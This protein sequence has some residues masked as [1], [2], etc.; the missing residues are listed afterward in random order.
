MEKLIALCKEKYDPS[1]WHEKSREAFEE[2]F[3][4]RYPVKA[5]TGLQFRTPKMGEDNVAFS[6]I[7]HSSNPSS[8]AYSG[9]S[10]VLFPISDGP[11]LIALGIGTQGLYPDDG[12]LGKPGH[13]RKTNAITKWLNSEFSKDASISWSK[14]DPTRKDLNIPLSVVNSFPNYSSIFERYGPEIYSFVVGSES[15]L[16]VALKAFIDLFLEE[17]GVVVRSK[18]EGDANRIKEKYFRYIFPITTIEN[19]AELLKKRKYLIV[20][21]PPGTGKT[22]LG[23]DLLKNTYGGKGFTIQFHANTTYEN[24]VGGLF[25]TKSNEAMGFTFKPKAGDFI[26][27]ISLAYNSSDAVLLVIDEINRADLSKVLGEAIYCLEPFDTG[28]EINLPFSFEELGGSLLQMPENLHILGLMNNSDRSISYID[29]AIRRRFAFLDFWPSIEVV[30]TQGSEL[31]LNLYRELVSIFLEFANDESITL[32]PGHSY[33]LTYPNVSDVGYLRTNL[34]PL[35]KDYIQQGYVGSFS[36][37]IHAYIQKV[38]S[39]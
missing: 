6:A 18:S 30:R 2:L 23:L 11:P 35:L 9:M 38:E 25:P 34:L 1:S 36:E 29:V 31:T 27:A 21:G 20:Q 37:H 10:F 39:L 8:G 24:F 19:V 32:M 15:V 28:R 3:D 16:E 33:F 14:Q 17:R 4:V 22:R 7:I 26:K 13:S 12:I 5:K